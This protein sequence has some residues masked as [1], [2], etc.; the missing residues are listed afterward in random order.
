[1]F[2]K[3]QNDGQFVTHQWTTLKPISNRGVDPQWVGSS[4]LAFCY[5]DVILQNFSKQN[6][7][8]SNEHNL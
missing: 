2:L 1:M 7:N 6:T 5:L 8:G 3:W 4:P